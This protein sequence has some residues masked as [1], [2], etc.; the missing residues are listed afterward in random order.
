MHLATQ[1]QNEAELVDYLGKQLSLGR[2]ALF[3]GAGVS[4][5]FGL[6]SWKELVR[7]LYRQ[8]KE[9]LPKVDTKRQVEQLRLLHYQDR[10]SAFLDAVQSAL[11]KGVKTD[12][13]DLRRNP[14]LAAIGA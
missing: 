3:L 2:I 14:T 13:D 9:R 12:A 7:R 10:H 1:Y 6:P 8:H 4:I 5:P 11:Y